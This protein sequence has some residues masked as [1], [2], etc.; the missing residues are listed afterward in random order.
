MSPEIRGGYI[1]QP[2]LFGDS[3]ASKMPPVTRELWF[4]IL[5]KV[6]HKK[7]GKFNRGQGF[8]SLSDIQEDLS[9]YVGYRKM[10]YS[11]PQLTKSL[12]RLRESNMVETMKAT[13][14]VLITVCKYNYYQDAKNYER[15][16]EGQPK[17]T[18]RKSSGRTKNKNDKNDKNVKNDKKRTKDGKSGNGEI[19]K[20][21]PHSFLSFSNDFY[22]YLSLNGGKKEYTRKQITDGADTIEKLVRIDKYDIETE[23]KAALGWGIKDEFWSKQIRS[24][25]TLRKK[26][27]KNGETKFTNLFNQYSARN[28][29]GQSQQEKIEISNANNAKIAAD[30]IMENCK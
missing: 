9:W 20:E 23:I 4:Y 30:I 7:V 8:F 26:S 1:L 22:R 25:S 17:E 5:R 21:I 14:G 24:L 18:R 16:D 19:K 27:D 2:R 12:R 15:N 6:N 3:E 28:V 11:K 10:K 13:R 29:T